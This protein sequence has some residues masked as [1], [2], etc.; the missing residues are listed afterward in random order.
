M[1]TT[2]AH[3]SRPMGEEGRFWLVCPRNVDTRTYV[4]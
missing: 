3:I 2:G 1:G 4:R